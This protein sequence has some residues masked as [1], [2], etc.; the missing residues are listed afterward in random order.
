MWCLGRGFGGITGQFSSGSRCVGLGMGFWVSEG[1]I[2][3]RLKECG[4]WDGVLGGW[5]VNFAQ[6]QCVMGFGWNFGWFRVQFS[7]GSRREGLGKGFWV[8]EVDLA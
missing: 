6:D 3:L 7:S 5:W 1:Y 4:T 2:L 8:G